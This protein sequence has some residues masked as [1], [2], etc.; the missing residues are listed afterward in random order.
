[1]TAQQV[2]KAT[3]IILLM[4]T[5][6]YVLAISARILIVLVVAVIIASAV[7]PIVTRLTLW[8]VPEGI[9]IA[10]VY[11]TLAALIL[12]LSVAVLPPVVN[13]V[14][15]YI[16]ND[17]RLAFQIIRAQR[18]VE[19]MISNVTDSEVS[20]VA[21]EEIRTAVTNSVVQVRRLMPSVLDNLGGTLGEAV[22]IFV[23]GAYWLTSHKKATAFITE[24]A[25]PRYREKS[26]RV[27][28]EV[29]ETMGGYVRG[30]VTIATIVGALN[31]IPMQLLGVP[32]ALT[33]SF[34]IAVMTII[35]MIGGLIGGLI[36]VFLT[37]IA[38]PVQYVPVVLI[39]FFVVQQLE[40]Y[41]LSPRI[42][43]N[44]VGLDPLLVI[45]Y[46]AIGFVLFGILGA[47]IA[48]PIMGSIHIL[49]QY[50]VIEPHKE[51]LQSFQNENG[52]A[53]LKPTVNEKPVVVTETQV[54][55]R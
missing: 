17:S 7:R 44:R 12:V 9:A 40:N 25:T 39:V 4:L 21:P 31:F 2:F 14:V 22:L 29:E 41:F 42:M 23:M 35:P 3:F 46:T 34:I 32:N 38:A 13:Q 27:I 15:Q 49:I 20:L 16:E 26:Q 53:I 37:L 18:W 8:R 1:M 6:A 43:A 5:C 24:L 47:L 55:E 28:E 11:F 51:N 36:A 52:Y 10:L 30:V 45:V 19:Q 50:L 54:Q 33:L 48:V